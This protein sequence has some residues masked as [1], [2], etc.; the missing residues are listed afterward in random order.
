MTNTNQHGGKKTF[1]GVISTIAVL[2]LGKLKFVLAILKF[3]KLHTLISLVISLG[4]YALFF[5]WKFAAAL[6]YL[7]FVHEM[8]HAYAARKI[9]LPV[10][11]AIFIPFMGAVIGL[12]EM[13]KNAKDE[14][15][16][17]YMGPLFGLLSFL[18]AFLLY[19]L[20]HEPFWALLIILGGTI[21]LFNLIP[22]TPLDGGRIAAGISTKLWALGIILLLAYSIKTLSVLGFFIAF[23]GASEWYKIYKKQKSLQNDKKEVQELDL[24]LIMLKQQSIDLDSIQGAIDQAKGRLFN[25]EMIE[26]INILDSEIKKMKRELLLQHLSGIHILSDEEENN[27]QQTIETI[28]RTLEEKISAYKQEVEITENYYQTSKKTKWQLFSIYIGLVLALTFSY[29]YGNN[30]LLNHPEIQEAMNR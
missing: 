22:I 27:N 9:K 26:Q 10:S 12:K 30:L 16:V 8:G 23:L 13:P 14:G 15:F 24:M 7:L 19:D 28:R 11:P 2:L 18:P 6:I 21:N 1:L 20:T 25:K 4:T 29:Y 5:G 17:A 3:L